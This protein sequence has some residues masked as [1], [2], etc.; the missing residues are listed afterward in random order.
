MTIRE[1]LIKIRNDSGLSQQEF[2]DKLNVA[3]QT[4]TRWEAGRSTPSSAQI[5][6]ICNVFG[7]DANEFLEGG[8]KPAEANAKELRLQK[9]K[10]LLPFIAIA[11]AAVAAIAG[12]IITIVYCAKDAAYDTTA[13]VWILAVPQNTPMIVLSVF[14]GAFILVLAALFIYL[15]KRGKK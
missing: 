5:L 8:I 12:L 2:A 11:A 14:L 13:T 3:R 15:L 10:K 7:L 6:N 4:V 9:I 1:K